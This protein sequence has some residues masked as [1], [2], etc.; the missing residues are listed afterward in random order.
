MEHPG[1]VHRTARRDPQGVREGQ[2]R[3]AGAARRELRGR[4]RNCDGAG[5]IDTDLAMMA[6][7]ATSC[8]ACE[9]RR[10]QAS[11]LDHHLGGRD[12]SEVLEMSMTEAEEF[13]PSSSDLARGTDPPGREQA[14]GAM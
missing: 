13:F 10:F 12:I 9:G 5:V 4:L 6:G 7:V 8:E 2:R 11:V 14:V 1:D 3:E